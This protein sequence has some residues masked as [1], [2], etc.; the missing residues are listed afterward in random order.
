MLITVAKKTLI[1]S[2]IGCIALCIGWSSCKPKENITTPFTRLIGKWQKVRYAT[3]DNGNGGLDEWEIHSTLPT[4]VETL[5]FKKDSTGVEK[6]TL[7]PDLKFHWFIGGDVSLYL[8]YSSGDTI[9]YKV[10]T[11]TAANL[12]LTTRTKLGLAGYYYDRK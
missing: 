9:A 4:N 11:N 8:V 1:I 10:V 5:E 2:L 7:S 12:H 6:G 3:D